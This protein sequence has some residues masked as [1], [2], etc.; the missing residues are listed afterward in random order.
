VDLKLPRRYGRRQQ[1]ATVEREEEL[2][3]GHEEIRFAGYVTVT[4]RTSVDL[5]D[6]CERVEQAAQQAYLE[7]A[8][9]WG[10]QDSGFVNGAL[11]VGRGLSTDRSGGLW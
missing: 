7:L 10:E 6:S 9:M 1:D 3:S 8:T 4:G 5:D 2:A 11:P